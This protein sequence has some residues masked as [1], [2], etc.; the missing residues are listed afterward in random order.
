MSEAFTTS[1]RCALKLRKAKLINAHQHAFLKELI[2]ADET[3]DL[4]VLLEKCCE[5]AA[6]ASYLTMLDNILLVETEKAYN[7]LF[8]S[9]PLSEGKK[10]SRAE[11]EE[12]KLLR[13]KSLT[14]G[15]VDFRN[16]AMVL[17]KL[18]VPAGSTFV[19][20]GSGTGRAVF[21]A[22]LVEDF[23]HCIGIELLEGLYNASQD[24]LSLWE[25]ETK[26][27][28][29]LAG[30]RQHISFH[31]ASFLDYDWSVGDI[32]FANSTCFDE[33]L[34]KQI[35]DK[36]VAMRAD[37]LFISFTKPLDS[38][39]FD[40]LESKRYRMSW[41]M[42]TVFIHRRRCARPAALPPC[43]PATSSR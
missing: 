23:A 18:G 32:V 33:S 35:A 7:S 15:E 25:A 31:R 19:D 36:A 28:L 21:A 16:F 11:R 26:P 10:L 8:R 14:Y 13:N 12:L 41:G 34:M 30:R 17:R 1:L 5:A 22:A 6:G 24:V 40:L 39:A 42:A 38:P 9:A 3:A 43:A 29:G 37:S 2:F 4:T 20:L 27:L